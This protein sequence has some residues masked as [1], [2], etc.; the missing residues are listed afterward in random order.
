MHTTRQRV[1]PYHRQGR[2]LGFAQGVEQA[3]APLTAFLV[4][5][6]TQFLTI[7][8]MSEGGGEAISSAQ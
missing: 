1:V 8:Y 4:G 2:V 5:P 6:L 7:P 3:A